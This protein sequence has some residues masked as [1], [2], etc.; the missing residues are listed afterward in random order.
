MIENWVQRIRNISVSERQ[1]CKS[2]QHSSLN[3]TTRVQAHNSSRTE[4]DAVA[5]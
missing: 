5:V 4:T 2:T 3:I 1:T